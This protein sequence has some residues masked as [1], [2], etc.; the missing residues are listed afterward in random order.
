MD[1]RSLSELSYSPSK[2]TFDVLTPNFIYLNSDKLSLY[3]VQKGEEMRMDLVIMS[4]YDDATFLA[5]IDV[6]L[7][8]NGIDNPLNINAGD[9]IYYP[10]SDQLSSYRYIAENLS[11]AGMSVRNRLATPNKTVKKDPN[12]KKFLDNGFALPPV[13]LDSAKAPVRVEND[14]IVIGGLNS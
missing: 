12:R 14:K 4:I 6:L 3:I 5:D 9:T 7:F 8:L 13:V 2:Q 11:N 1:I 10:P